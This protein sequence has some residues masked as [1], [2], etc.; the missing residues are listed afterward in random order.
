MII[1]IDFS[2]LSSYKIYFSSS[3]FH[4][5]SSSS[6]CSCSSFTYLY[7]SSS[8]ISVDKSTPL[9]VVFRE[10]I[11]NEFVVSILLLKYVAVHALWNIS[12]FVALLLSIAVSH[13]V[14]FVLHSP[15]SFLVLSP[16]QLFFFVPFYD[17]SPPV[18]HHNSLLVG[19]P[20]EFSVAS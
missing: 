13:S 20:N 1:V 11:E 3:F 8:S 15:I 16:L 5:F 10:F 7:F 18:S 19:F 2:N 4:F 12:L 6:F 17:L 14:I 9:S